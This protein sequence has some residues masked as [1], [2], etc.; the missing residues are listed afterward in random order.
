MLQYTFK[1]ARIAGSTAETCSNKEPESTVNVC[2][3]IPEDV[4]RAPKQLTPSSSEVTDEQQFFFTPVDKENQTKEQT[5]DRKEQSWKNAT[6]WVAN[7]ETSSKKQSIE[8]FK[9]MDGNRT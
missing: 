7:E 1:I 6:E 2:L 5:V 3:K 8:E 9:K 4:T